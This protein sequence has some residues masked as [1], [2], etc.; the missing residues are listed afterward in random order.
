[1]IITLAARAGAAANHHV[2]A[3]S[4]SASRPTRGAVYGAR[5]NAR[6]GPA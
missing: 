6:A 3:R 5:T 1:M 2:D 4:A